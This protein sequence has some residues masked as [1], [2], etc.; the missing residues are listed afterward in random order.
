[1]T[2]EWFNKEPGSDIAVSTDDPSMA[3]IGGGVPDWVRLPSD[4]GGQ[5]ARVLAASVRP[6]PR[7]PHDVRHLKLDGDISVAEC[8]DHGGFLWYRTPAEVTS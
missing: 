6:C 5:R 1:M 3:L 4:L 8:E 2:V 7:G